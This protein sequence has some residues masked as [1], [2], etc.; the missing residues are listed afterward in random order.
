MHHF[1]LYSYMIF[2]VFGVY[3][4]VQI[5]FLVPIHL[6]VSKCQHAYGGLRV[7]SWIILNHS[8]MPFI[9]VGPPQTLE[10]FWQWLICFPV[11]S[12]GSSFHIWGRNYWQASKSIFY[13]TCDLRMPNLVLSHILLSCLSRN[14]F[15][16]MRF[17]YKTY[18]NIKYIL[19]CRHC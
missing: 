1:V 3:I 13:V 14:I 10:L 19:E 11:C 18:C 16:N 9:E 12:V 7:I 17:M 4:C 6:C 15:I 2:Y 5:I 8:S